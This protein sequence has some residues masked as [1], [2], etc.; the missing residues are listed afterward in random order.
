MVE[1]Y[2]RYA[3]HAGGGSDPGST[4]K[5]FMAALRYFRQ[6]SRRVKLFWKISWVA[7]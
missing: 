1:C 4:D 7:R 2:K 5:A 6:D 3:G